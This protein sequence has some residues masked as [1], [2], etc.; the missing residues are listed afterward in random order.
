MECMAQAGCEPEP[1]FL[2][3][4]LLPGVSL[5]SSSNLE[6]QQQQQQQQRRQ[7]HTARCTAAGPTPERASAGKPPAVL[8][9]PEAQAQDDLLVGGSQDSLL[10]QAQ[11][12]KV[13]ASVQPQQQQDQAWPAAAATAA[14][15][16]SP[17]A[18]GCKLLWCMGR[19]RLE[20]KPQLF[21][22]LLLQLEL[23]P[24]QL[25]QMKAADRVDL[26]VG[27]SRL[28]PKLPGVLQPDLYCLICEGFAGHQ[29]LKA[30]EVANIIRSMGSIAD[31]TTAGAVS[32]ALVAELL[33][34]Q[35]GV[36]GI[37]TMDAIEATAPGKDGSRGAATE[38]C[39]AQQPH[40]EQESMCL[41]S[42]SKAATAAATVAAAARCCCRELAH[43][44]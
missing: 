23:Q 21:S 40:N 38:E 5:W 3:Q 19:L 10:Q 26:I 35:G 42:R 13:P 14:A 22:W 36:G 8:G 28:V 44:G 29:R 34:G 16:S 6:Q 37:E 15:A 9:T 43:R 41:P 39:R 12:Q 1:E 25:Q 17:T 27:L 4:Y 30:M 20:P 24:D 11:L 2:E 31:S 32:G 7:R 33:A 18:V